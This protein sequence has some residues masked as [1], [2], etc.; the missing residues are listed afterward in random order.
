MQALA[1]DY[2]LHIDHA[3][4]MTT[5]V[6]S[7][8]H[9]NFQKRHLIC[10]PAYE[11]R[12]NAGHAH[13]NA[14]TQ[15]AACYIGPLFRRN[16]SSVLLSRLDR[17]TDCVKSVECLT[18]DAPLKLDDIHQPEGTYTATASSRRCSVRCAA[19]TLYV[20]C[21][22]RKT[23]RTGLVDCERPNCTRR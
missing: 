17:S 19:V 2:P 16:R 5:G 6:N 8:S 22:V 3:I 20:V 7:R 11:S 18:A 21:P 10:T 15:R 13:N 1:H 23:A 4:L 14:V 12:V 9:V